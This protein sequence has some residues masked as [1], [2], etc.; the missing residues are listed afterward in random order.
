MKIALSGYS[1][2]IGSTLEEELSKEPHE[3]IRL[4][5]DLLYD[6]KGHSLI[7]QLAGV[8]VVIHLSGSPILK[9]W[10]KKNRT[11]IF[12]SRITTT[13]N[14]IA[15]IKALPFEKRPKIFISASAIGIYQ[16]GQIHTENSKN[17]AGHFAAQVIRDWEQAS[18]SLPNNVRR[19]IFR[20]GLV[21]EKNSQLIKQLKLPFLL[22]AGGPIGSG[23]QPFPFIHLRDVTGAIRWSLKNNNVNGIYNLVSP[24]QITNSQFSKHFARKLSRPSWLPVPKLPLKILF[25]QAAQLVYESPGVIPERLIHEEYPF[26]YPD[27]ESALNSFL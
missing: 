21:I 15:A 4:K 18:E 7:S 24:D 8:D 19:V 10:N 1:G 6:H 5:R 25:G 26:K 17:I 23:K 3:I 2:L 27:I 12:E 14:L 13:T 20:I 16:S 22:F 11:E 9:K